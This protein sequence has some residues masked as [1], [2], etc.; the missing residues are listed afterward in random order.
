M[1]QLLRLAMWIFV[2]Y[3]LVEFV[4]DFQSVVDGFSNFM[5]GVSS[6]LDPLKGI[7]K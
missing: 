1:A 4:T 2:T 7:I 6:I 3:I 5:D